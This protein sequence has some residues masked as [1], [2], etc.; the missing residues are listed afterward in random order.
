MFIFYQKDKEENNETLTLNIRKLGDFRYFNYITFTKNC[1]WQISE[2]Y[3]NPSLRILLP[4]CF[5]L[6]DC[7]KLE[8]EL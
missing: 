6:T 5:I 8:Y 4:L 7:A 3:R 1:N 2:W